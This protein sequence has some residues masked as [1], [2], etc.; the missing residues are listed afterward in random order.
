MYFNNDSHKDGNGDFP[1]G[2]GTQLFNHG[3][4]VADATKLNT[5]PGSNGAVE[6][7]G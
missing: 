7:N 3:P 6:M 1:T 5:G 2:K 4:F